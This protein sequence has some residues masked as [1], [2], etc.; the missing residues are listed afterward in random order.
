MKKWISI[1]LAVVMVSLAACAAM[2]DDKP[3]PEGGK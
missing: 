1:L 3:Q 2:A